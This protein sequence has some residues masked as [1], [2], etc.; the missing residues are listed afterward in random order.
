MSQ[1]LGKSRRN[2]GI[3]DVTYFP[4]QRYS[5]SYL[6]LVTAEKLFLYHEVVKFE[7]KISEANNHQ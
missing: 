5:L 4:A 7:S 6:Y 1:I 3:S 2:F